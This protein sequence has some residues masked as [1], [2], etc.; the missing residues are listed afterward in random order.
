MA[1]VQSEKA[2]LLERLK[3]VGTWRRFGVF[4]PVYEIVGAGAALAGGDQ[5]MRVRVVETG[6]ELDY[7]VAEILADPVAC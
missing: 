7:R 2:A 1:D 6:E 4:G 5:H 3:L